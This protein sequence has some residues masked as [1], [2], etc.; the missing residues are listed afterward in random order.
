MCAAIALLVTTGA[1]IY[2]GR[3]WEEQQRQSDLTAKTLEAQRLHEDVKLMGETLQDI[4]ILEQEI[5]DSRRKFAL[6]IAGNGVRHDG[7]GGIDTTKKDFKVRQ[8]LRPR[9]RRWAALI[10]WVFVMR[11]AGIGRGDGRFELIFGKPRIG[12]WK[13]KLAVWYGLELFCPEVED[14]PETLKELGIKSWEEL[15]TVPGHPATIQTT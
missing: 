11:S 13:N 5:E 1:L 2:A 15:G 3:A 10:E 8:F 7:H 4:L 12:T 14:F 6:Q 9:V